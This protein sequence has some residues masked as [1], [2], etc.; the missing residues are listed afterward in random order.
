MGTEENGHLRDMENLEQTNTWGKW[1]FE[2]KG[3]SGRVG[4]EVNGDFG[5]IGSWKK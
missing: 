5:Q 3:H 2:A 1:A 4:T